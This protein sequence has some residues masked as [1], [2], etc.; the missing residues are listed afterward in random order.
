M[1]A[2]ETPAMRPR[3]RDGGRLRVGLVGAGDISRNHFIAWARAARAEVVA[4]CDR[5][6]ARARARADEFAIPTVYTDAREMLARED[7]DVLDVATW[8]DTHAELVR[9][10]ADHG[11]DVLCQKP[12]AR[13]LD[14]AEALVADVEG[15]IRVMVN[16]NRR[17]AGRFR[18]IGRWIA[19]GR[20]GEL[21]QC[22]MIMHRSG[23]LKDADGRRPA[24]ERTAGM[25][26]EPRLMVQEALIH[27][28]DVLRSLLGRL[29][30]VAARTLYTEPDMPGETLATLFFETP[31]GAPVIVAG[32]FVAPGFGTVVSD[33]L[34]IIGSR[35]S[36]VLD[37]DRL[38]IMNGGREEVVIDM[39]ADYQ[40]CFDVAMAHFAQCL[41]DGVAFESDVRDNLETLRLVEEIYRV[42]ARPGHR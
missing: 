17:F 30:V 19:E 14:E 9:L 26:D 35:S 38:V 31:N 36:I 40:A 42:A 39:A 11:V 1:T 15:R 23:F 25:A 27:Q 24:V 33:R 16:E 20:L 32:S 29:D 6:A 21:R 41:W 13:T 28:I 5:D 2:G 37:G 3:Q 7:L 18:T 8:R 4:V 12:L 10:A 34:E 22:N